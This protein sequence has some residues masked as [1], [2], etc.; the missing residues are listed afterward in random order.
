MF[1]VVVVNVNRVLGGFKNNN[2][3]MRTQKGPWTS[4]NPFWKSRLFYPNNFPPNSI[5]NRSKCSW[6]K[7]GPP[8]FSKLCSPNFELFM[9]IDCPCCLVPVKSLDGKVRIFLV[10]LK[11]Q[12]AI[13]NLEARSKTSKHDSKCQRTIQNVQPSA[14]TSKHELKSQSTSENIKLSVKTWNSQPKHWNA[15]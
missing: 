14:K 2:L 11:R 13:E 3:R 5:I 12:S 8:C 10:L 9:V 1:T 6:Y 7:T 15:S 4:K